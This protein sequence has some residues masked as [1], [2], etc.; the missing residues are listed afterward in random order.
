VNPAGAHLQGA[1]MSSITADTLVLTG[2]GMPNSS[3]LYFQGTLRQSGGAGQVFGDGKRCAGGSVVRL[4]IKFN[5]GGTS[6]YPVFGDQSV[7]V[8]GLVTVPGARTYQTWYR[9]A[10]IFC[11][12]STFN[13]TN[14]LDVIW[15]P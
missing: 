9:N 8:R 6:Q 10:A 12:S 11:T 3:A 2:T 14:G 5:A 15:A 7:S 13:L 4:G 1:G